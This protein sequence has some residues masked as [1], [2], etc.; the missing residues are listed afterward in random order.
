MIQTLPDRPLD[1]VG[2]VHGEL[3]ALENLIEH[4]GY[5]PDGSHPE[6]RRLVFVGDLCDRGPDSPGVLKRV[7]SLVQ[8][9]SAYALLGNHEL[10]LLRGERKDGM[11]WWNPERL[12]RDGHY[13]R[14][15][16]V[17]DHERAEIL[18]WVASLPVLL[19]RADLR[20][21][22]AAWGAAQVALVRQQL[23]EHPARGVR[24][25]DQLWDAAWRQ[26]LADSGWQA[27][28]ERDETTW[29]AEL[30]DP[31]ATLP[32]LAAIAHTDLARQQINPLKLLTSGEERL[33]EQP[34]FAGHKWR[35]TKRV[36]WWDYYV[37]DVPVVVGHYWRLPERPA[38]LLPG[39]SLQALG[40][41]FRSTAPHEWHGQRSNVFCID[42]SVGA[43]YR[44]RKLGQATPLP[45]HFSLGALRWPERELVLDCGRRFATHP[46][47]LASARSVE[48]SDRSQGNV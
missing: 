48:A 13:G 45:S 32:V 15:R 6:D 11:G 26:H 38:G 28:R 5:R 25:Q 43:R 19:E 17:A 39:V 18:S 40:D 7:R 2:D 20:V 27:Q 14:V 33:V 16:T 35:F 46:A 41:E 30:E 4:L 3:T 22:H 42:F 1:I 8:Q 29:A 23:V 12:P 34:F 47:A 44:E 10:N 21:V 9:G 36:R 24:E 37:D 31:E